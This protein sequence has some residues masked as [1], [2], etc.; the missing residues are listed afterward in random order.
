MLNIIGIL[1][2]Y[3]YYKISNLKLSDLNKY[4]ILDYLNF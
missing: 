4:S 3:I 2:I 1:N